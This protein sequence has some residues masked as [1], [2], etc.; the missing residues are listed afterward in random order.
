MR[1]HLLRTSI[2]KSLY[3]LTKPP[4]KT[5]LSSQRT[6]T[7][8]T[9]TTATTTTPTAASTDKKKIP[10]Y[11][12]STFR[13]YQG[14]VVKPFG[15]EWGM[16]AD[17]HLYFVPSSEDQ[18]ALCAVELKDNRL[19]HR[20]IVEAYNR[21]CC[22]KDI[23]SFVKEEDIETIEW[24]A[25]NTIGISGDKDD[26]GCGGGKMSGGRHRHHIRVEWNK[27]HRNRIP[28]S[29]I[30]TRSDESL[31]ELLQQDKTAKGIGQPAEVWINGDYV[32]DLDGSKESQN[33]VKTALQAL[34]SS[35]NKK[36]WKRHSENDK[37]I[38]IERYYY[39]GI[40]RKP[41]VFDHVWDNLVALEDPEIIDDQTLIGTASLSD[42]IMGGILTS[43]LWIQ[44]LGHKIV[45]L[46]PLRNDNIDSSDRRYELSIS[47]GGGDGASNVEKKMAMVRNELKRL[48]YLASLRH[49]F[50][51][52]VATQSDHKATTSD[53]NTHIGRMA[54]IRSNLRRNKKKGKFFA[55]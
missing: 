22:A 54:E 21:W 33:E 20:G 40:R 5:T 11:I 7:T 14:E 42:W 46:R 35:S 2:Q 47:A 50:N 6:M 43:R 17:S 32:C 10:V 4:R 28:I 1:R 48:R 44:D 52:V 23:P 37:M 34:P 15:L 39:G 26:G 36:N 51:V 9:M 8:T 49:P 24:V 30:P 13:D 25:E 27:E 55:I 18:E 41:E 53:N 12:H 31:L 45:F 29:N 16:D 3:F 38:R 19:L